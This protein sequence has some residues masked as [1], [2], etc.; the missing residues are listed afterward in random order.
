MYTC[1][2]SPPGPY[3]RPYDTENSFRVEDAYKP[4]G[5]SC[6]YPQQNK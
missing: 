5:K 1:P 2:K 6:K 3:Y 4:K